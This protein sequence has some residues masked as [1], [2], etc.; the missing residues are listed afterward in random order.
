MLFFFKLS[1]GFNGNIEIGN[2]VIRL[3]QR[4]F[5]YVKLLYKKKPILIKNL[6]NSYIIQWMGIICKC[7]Q[8]VFQE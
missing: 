6:K 1:N 7:F 4:I 2:T 3:H 8:E 5:K